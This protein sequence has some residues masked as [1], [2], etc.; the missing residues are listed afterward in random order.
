MQFG[1]F[2][3]L[4]SPDVQPSPTV[5]DNAIEQAELADK[6]GFNTVWLAEHHFSSYGY[7]PYP[8]M[9]AIKIAE[10]TKSIRVGTAVLVLPL[11][12]PIKLAEEI[13]MADQLTNGRIEIGF[14]RG[15]QEY[16]FDRLGVDINENREMFDESL[17][18]IS[19]ALQE[20]TITYD[21][22]YYQIDD[23]PNLNKKLKILHIYK[24][25]SH[26]QSQR[27]EANLNITLCLVVLQESLIPLLEE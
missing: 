6:L 2:L 7:L 18:I 16:E 10:R 21:G 22:K 1:V 20:D 11:H 25:I 12:H 23:F 27:K 8:L 15:Y 14:G 4:Q 9:M 5:Y 3:L 17:E 19:K 13:A 26:L 24:N